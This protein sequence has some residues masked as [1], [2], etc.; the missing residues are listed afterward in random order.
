MNESRTP[1]APR[2][3]G[4][5]EACPGCGAVTLTAV[6]DGESTNFFCGTCEKCWRLELGWV[7]RIEPRTCP[8]CYLS[9]RCAAAR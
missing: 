4:A 1:I 3:W 2:G 5:L 9:S 8:G 7:S 6:S